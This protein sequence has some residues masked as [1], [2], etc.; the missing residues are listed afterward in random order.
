VCVV[1]AGG[2]VQGKGLVPGRDE[3]P[4]LASS[5]TGSMRFGTAVSPRDGAQAGAVL[6]SLEDPSTTDALRACKESSHSVS[7]IML[8][9]AV[10]G[11]CGAGSIVAIAFDLH[12]EHASL[13]NQ[14]RI[15]STGGSSIPT[16]VLHRPAI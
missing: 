3:Q 2:G 16:A 8:V 11:S 6:P 5:G 13:W 4:W 1:G 7:S 12:P 14:I 10:I 15:N 9:E